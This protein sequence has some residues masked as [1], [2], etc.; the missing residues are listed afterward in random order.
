[1]T[2]AAL[3]LLV[4]GA[5]CTSSKKDKAADPTSGP[6]GTASASATPTPKAPRT[7]EELATRFFTAWQTGDFAALTL[8]TDADA[9]M[10][11]KMH[12]DTAK[13]L[14]ASKTGFTVGDIEVNGVAATA[15]FT[16]KY[17]LPG[18]GEW[19]YD[20]TL[21]MT[22]VKDNA[23]AVAWTPA[24]VHPQLKD[25]Q[26]LARTRSL[27]RRGDVLDAAGKPL[28]ARTE[29]ITVGIE[30]RRIKDAD[31]TYAA[32]TA[33]ITA[34]IKALKAKVAKAEPDG[35]VPI[36]TM[37]R[38]QFTPLRPRL[39][40]IPGVVFQTTGDLSPPTPTF[41]R[42]LLGRVGEASKEVLDAAGT[43]YQG[44]DHLG[45]FGLQAAFQERLSGTPTGAVLIKFGNTTVEQLQEFKG[46]PAQAVKTT[47]V[48]RIQNAAEAALGQ[49]KVA[50][51]M[52]VIKPSTGAILAAANRPDDNR[53]NRAF[54]GQ[55][56]PGSTMKVITTAALIRAGV[57]LN[58]SV[59]CPPTVK[60][61]GKTFRNFEGEAAGPQA[62][63]KDFAHSCNTAF[64]SLNGRLKDNDL[65]AVAAG[66]GVGGDWKLPMPAYTGSVPEPKDQTDLA[67]SMIGQGRVLVSPLGMATVAAAVANGTWRSPVLV[68]SPASD[69]AQQVRRLDPSLVANLRAL[70]RQ[71]VVEGTG[72][73]AAVPGA[74][75]SGKTGTAEFGNATPLQT[76]A[77][78]IGFRGDLAVAV[79][80][81]GG[82]IGGRDA[83]PI[84]G[85]FFS[86]VG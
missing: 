66:F 84:A 28:F 33:I 72:K 59:P 22:E 43:A 52:V 67:A 23:W 70:M 36:V 7:P 61:L 41:A 12:E 82:G 27:P 45:L 58:D 49:P 83:A 19:S 53:L 4:M 20:G 37:T 60:V 17:E 15:P 24:V 3:A 5:A 47:I 14:G 32:V 31:A 71:V 65:G 73:A 6:T 1:M 57:R 74:P 30:P 48:P 78:F 85:K 26:R 62:F 8:L 35:F 69:E 76:H 46:K 29:K 68:T 75:V 39:N 21:P 51:A 16:V 63:S 25:G 79:L 13:G 2:A 55:Y 42:A 64:I 54:T 9:A 10:V 38:A 81:E 80:L 44:G 18:L 50:A 40:P 34:D 77:W 56:P 11:Q 86:L